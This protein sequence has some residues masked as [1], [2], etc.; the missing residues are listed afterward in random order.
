MPGFREYAVRHLAGHLPA[1]QLGHLDDPRLFL[2]RER[3]TSSTR[4]EKGGDIANVSLVRPLTAED[5]V[6][7]SPNL[8][9][10]LDQISDELAGETYEEIKDTL[11]LL[12]PHAVEGVKKLR[13][14]SPYDGGYVVL[15]D[16]RGVDT[17]FS[18]GIEKNATWDLDVAKRGITVYQFD[19]TVDAP[20]SAMAA[21]IGPL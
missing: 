2:A 16:F 10:A 21:P 14:G 4:S 17:A 8:R 20:V 3:L 19:H 9:E 5:F 13:L 15:D 1:I 18:L 11:R 7:D 6:R 12:R